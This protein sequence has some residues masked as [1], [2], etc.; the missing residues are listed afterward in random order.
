MWL[1]KL[2]ATCSNWV[3]AQH[4]SGRRSMRV[5]TLLKKEEDGSL[6]ARKAKE[7]TA[8][9]VL[10]SETVNYSITKR[11]EQGNSRAFKFPS[12][13]DPLLSTTKRQD[14]RDISTNTQTSTPSDKLASMCAELTKLAASGVLGKALNT[15]AHAEGPIEVGGLLGLASPNVDNMVAKYRARKSGL[16][17]ASGRPTEEG[18]ESK[19]LIPERLHDAIEAGGLGLLAAPYAAKRLHTGSWH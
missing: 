17:D 15:V 11:D 5:S 10:P 3:Q 9:E 18:I 8:S 16:V 6:F 14:M 13:D 1:D 7:K 2:A 4:R 12:K 19:R